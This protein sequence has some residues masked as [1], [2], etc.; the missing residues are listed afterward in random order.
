[1][2]G[3]GEWIAVSAVRQHELAFVV[4]APQVIGVFAVAE[5]RSHGLVL[6]PLAVLHQPPPVEH[7]MDR[8]DC[9]PMCIGITSRQKL[10]DLR[11]TPTRLLLLQPDNQGLDLEWQL[12][13]MTIGP[14][15][16]VRQSLKARLLITINDLVSRLARDAKL[17][18]KPRHL[19]ALQK[20]GDEL[21]AFVHNV[22][23]LPRHDDLPKGKKV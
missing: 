14:A 3:D 18:G 21:H 8:A 4:R 17:I 19:L 12:V 13:G 1:V 7:G 11:C 10:R 20:P 22:T 6:S 9:R 23:L 5:D 15:A 16:P 2:V